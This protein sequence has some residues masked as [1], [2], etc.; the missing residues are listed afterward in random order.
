[1]FYRY[2][3]QE[4][5]KH[6]NTI[7]LYDCFSNSQTPRFCCDLSYSNKKTIQPV[8]LSKKKAKNWKLL[9][10][11]QQMYMILWHYKPRKH[12]ALYSAKYRTAHRIYGHRMPYCS[13]ERLPQLTLQHLLS[14]HLSGDMQLLLASRLKIKAQ[15]KPFIWSLLCNVFN[16]CSLLLSIILLPVFHRCMTQSSAV[17]QH[18]QLQC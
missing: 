7:T 10:P 5:W 11:V 16:Y 17:I 8:G 3:W 1:V 13:L 4:A 9:Q 15:L 6:F 2:R 18:C 12:K 14:I